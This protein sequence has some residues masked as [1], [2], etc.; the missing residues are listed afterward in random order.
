VA[1]AATL[2][3][4]NGYDVCWLDGIA[5][6]WT[7]DIWYQKLV[8][9]SPDYIFIETKT[10]VIKRHWKIINQIKKSLPET[11]VVLAGDHVTALPEES[12]ES[13][14]VDYIIS[15]G[16]YD[17]GLLEILRS[18]PKNKLVK[19]KQSDLNKMP[20]IDR[21]LT[22][23]QLYA[24]KN[25]NFKYTPGTYIMAGR[26]CWWRRDGGCT[27]CSWTTIFPQFSVRSVENVLDEVGHLI[28]LGIKE[29]FDDTGTFPIGKWLSDFCKGMIERGYHKQVMIGCNMRFGYLTEAD[30]SLMVKANFRFLL[31]GLESANQL[32]VDRLNK[33]TII[34]DIESELAVIKNVGHLEP[35]VTC[36]IGYP[37]ETKA[38]AQRTVDL[39]KSYFKKGLINSL[40]AT[41]MIPYP[42]T[43]LYQ[44]AVDNKWLLTTDW[45]RFDMKEPILKS[46]CTDRDI[47]RL[48]QSIYL[49]AFTP[50]FVVKKIHSI[51]SF[52]DIS[53]LIQNSVRFL[54]RL[55]DFN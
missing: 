39:C 30:Y 23:W 45:D 29:I 43:K 35:H 5:E 7:F 10:P 54:A 13:S 52:N 4:N 25:G 24:I 16:F 31:F 20:F 44:E 55:I 28:T 19:A 36:M 46:A 6:G 38:D 47:H 27:F 8:D 53:I 14:A 22:K 1:Q 21:T 42:G 37:W 33:G 34:A 51:H 26:D 49:S 3:K 12:F 11:I 41:V 18:N 9:F 15:G 32:T 40:Q 50:A 17:T 2:L 48:T